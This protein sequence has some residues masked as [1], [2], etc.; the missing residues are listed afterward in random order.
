[1]ILGKILDTR[2][3]ILKLK[4]TKLDFGWGCAPGPAGGAYNAPPYSLAGY[5]GAYFYVKRRGGRARERRGPTSKARGEREGT[6]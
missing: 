6:G 1:L 5:N 4:S 2:C 3:H